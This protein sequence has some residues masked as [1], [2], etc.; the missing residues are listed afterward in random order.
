MSFAGLPVALSALA[1]EIRPEIFP[2]NLKKLLIPGTAVLYFAKVRDFATQIEKSGS[3][4][5]KG[6]DVPRGGGSSSSA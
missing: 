6:N 2:E 1:S 3:C 5:D 4:H